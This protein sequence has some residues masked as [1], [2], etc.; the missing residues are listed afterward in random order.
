MTLM[1]QA[2]LLPVDD[3]HVEV[4]PEGDAG[5][6]TPRQVDV[7]T[8]FANGRS[9]KQIGRTLHCSP[10]TVRSHIVKAGV[11]LG[12]RNKMHV[13]ALAVARGFVVVEI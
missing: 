10:R 6:L 8:M 12:A 9:Q 13:I 7:L 5:Q 3:G 11:K 2:I 4:A 1:A